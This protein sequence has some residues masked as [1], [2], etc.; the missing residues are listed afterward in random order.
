MDMHPSV[1]FLCQA[2]LVF[3]ALGFFALSGAALGKP[4]SATDVQAGAAFFAGGCA[5]VFAATRFSEPGKRKSAAT[6]MGVGGV[7]F[8]MMSAIFVPVFASARQAGITTTCMSNLK[9]TSVALA[10]YSADE[11]DTYPP[12][13]RWLTLSRP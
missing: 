13:D 12:A 8:W 5:L 7:I 2:T 10:T 1:K 6:A 4:R 9:S 11:D 3:L